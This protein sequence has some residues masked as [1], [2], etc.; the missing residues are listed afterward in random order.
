MSW[1]PIRKILAALITAVIAGGVLTGIITQVD[2][3]TV[4]GLLTAVA[5][6]LPVI[7]G[8]LVPSAP[9][10]AAPPQS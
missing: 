6:I 8:Y 10:E 7:V 9:G 3:Q 2:D 5:A 1:T 4:K